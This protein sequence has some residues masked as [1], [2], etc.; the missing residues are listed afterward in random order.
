MHCH[1]C[2]GLRSTLDIANSSACRATPPWPA[3]ALKVSRPPAEASLPFKASVASG[4]SCKI[5]Q[6]S[7][8]RMVIGSPSCICRA[9][10]DSL[11]WGHYKA[12]NCYRPVRRQAHAAARHHRKTG[13]HSLHSDCLAFGLRQSWHYSRGERVGAE[14]LQPKHK[15]V[16]VLRC[17]R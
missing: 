14:S 2:R 17:R 13:T 7:G 1:S 8:M 11:R 16:L 15:Q 12:G 5:L 4:A 10:Q 6:L 9:V 3:L